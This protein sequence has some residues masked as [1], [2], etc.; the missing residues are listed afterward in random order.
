MVWPGLVLSSIIVALLGVERDLGPRPTLSKRS[1]ACLRSASCS[2]WRKR[3]R[4]VASSSSSEDS[5]SSSSSAALRRRA[6]SRCS[7]IRCDFDF[8]FAAASASALAF[9]AAAFAA[10][11]RSASESSASSQLSA[12]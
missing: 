11:S 7:S 1:W 9:A 5:S 8:L 4:F 10:F 2:V 6:A 3:A 12:T